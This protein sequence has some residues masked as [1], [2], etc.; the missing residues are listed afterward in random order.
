MDFEYTVSICHYEMSETVAESIRSIH[1]HTDERYEILVVDGGSNDGSLELLRELENEFDRLRVVVSGTGQL[2]DD[3]NLGVEEARGSHVLLQID[4]DDRYCRGITDF[5]AVYEALR[6]VRQDPF[7]LKGNNINIGPKCL[8]LDHGP[9]RHGLNRGEDHDLWRRLFAADEIIWLDHAPIS[10][11]IGYDQSLWC[12]AIERV[13]RLRTEVI[14]GVSPGSLARW[15]VRNRSTV[16]AVYDLMVLVFV[17][18]TTRGDNRYA[19][20]EEVRRKGALREMID[21]HRTTVRQLEAE[22]GISI[23]D[24]LSDTGRQKFCEENSNDGSLLN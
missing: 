19:L 13:D 10:E 8:L 1:R 11:S 3:R 12:R 23:C 9:Y 15:T 20:P 14:S 7:Y 21:Q 18:L 4:A 5:V 6:G 17:L 2:S 16:A 22:N 24:S